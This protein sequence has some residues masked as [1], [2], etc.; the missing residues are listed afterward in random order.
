MHALQGGGGFAERLI[1]RR[2]TKR[3]RGGPQR[4][5]GSILRRD[6]RL[7]RG[8]IARCAGTIGGAEK[9]FCRATRAEQRRLARDFIIREQAARP[10][11]LSTRRGWRIHGAVDFLA[12]F[13]NGGHQGGT[14]YT[15]RGA[16]RCDLAFR[17]LSRFL[18]GFQRGAK[19]AE[20]SGK[21]GAGCLDGS[22][23]LRIGAQQYIQAVF[24]LTRAA[25]CIRQFHIGSCQQH[26]RHSAGKLRGTFSNIKAARQ[27]GQA[28]ISRRRGQALRQAIHDAGRAQSG[29]PGDKAKPQKRAFVGWRL[30]IG[31]HRIFRTSMINDEARILGEIPEQAV[32]KNAYFSIRHST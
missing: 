25:P 29:Q 32:R 7:V 17:F 22:R 19:L 23:N 14:K 9:F 21:T 1:A 5:K 6:Q 2:I 18:F 8:I 11:R 12:H 30:R 31:G 26:R 24:C 4:G 10:G 16:K 28:R 13:F 3:G 15:M 27:H 20:S